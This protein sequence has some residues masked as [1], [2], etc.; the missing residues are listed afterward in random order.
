VRNVDQRGV[1]DIKVDYN[2]FEFSDS[3]L[4]NKGKILLYLVIDLYLMK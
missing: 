2:A 3:R 4:I 1:I